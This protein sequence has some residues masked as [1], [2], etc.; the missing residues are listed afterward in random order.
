MRPLTR[1]QML[2]TA[3]AAPLLAVRAVAA[4]YPDRPVRVVIP[5]SAGGVPETIMRLLSVSMEKRLGQRL[6]LEAKPG[7]AGNIGTQEVARAAPD[8]YTLLV[9]ATN[10][11]AINQFVLKMTFD[12]LKTLAPIAKVA[13]VPLV[14]FSNP[15][16]P[17][18]TLKEF[19][20]YAK[21]NPGKVN[22]GIPSLGTVNHLLMERLKRAAGVDI[23]AV[24]YKGSPPALLA[25]L[26]NEIQIFPIG[27]AAVHGYYREGKVTAL[28]VATEKRIPMLPEVP[29]LIE[30]GF[31]GFVASNWFGMAAPAGTPPQILDTLAAAVSEAQQTK[32]VTDRFATMG[33]LV[34]HETRQQF[35]ASIKAEAA[36]WQETARRAHISIQ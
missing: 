30:S 11:F 16:V 12:P 22:Y 28:A 23:P 9:A 31:P 35:A 1:R 6:V 26:K 3:A 32:L 17:A 25:L 33:M 15:Q 7:A 5:Y 36:V 21:A 19:I 20:A 24:P 2:A 14:L 4:G 18:R 10:N 34:P 29:T 8:G 27:L 13:D